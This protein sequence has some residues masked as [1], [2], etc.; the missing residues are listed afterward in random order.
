[1]E[2]IEYP[3]VTLNFETYTMLYNAYNELESI[4][5]LLNDKAVEYDEEVEKISFDLFVV[6]DLIKLMKYTDGN[7]YYAMINKL[8]NKQQRAKQ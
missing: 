5:N 2:K 1:M 3:N 8:K 7:F 4:K 6:E